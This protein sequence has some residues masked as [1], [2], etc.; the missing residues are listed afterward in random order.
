MFDFLVQPETAPFTIALVLMMLIGIVEALGL[1]GS[2]IDI[3]MEGAAIGEGLDWLNVGRLPILIILVVFLTVFGLA[4]LALQQAAVTML[5]GLLQWF[6]A[7]PAAAVLALPGTRLLSRGLAKV[8]PRDETSAVEID[9]LLGRR[10][11][12][13][14]GTATRTSPARARVEDRFGQVHFV[15]VEPVE[16]T[17]LTAHDE[18]LLTSRD[19]TIFRAVAIEPDIFSELGPLP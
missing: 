13:V 12:I 14:L 17:R 7:V 1:G 9:S 19:G 3:D 4:G 15:M 16:D 10:A 8:L 5:G 11:R 18:L 2:A 6:V